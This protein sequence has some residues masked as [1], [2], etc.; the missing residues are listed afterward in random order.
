MNRHSTY[1]RYLVLFVIIVERSGDLFICQ[2]QYG[3]IHQ[4]SRLVSGYMVAF[5]VRFYLSPKTFE[6]D[7][8]LDTY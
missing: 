3:Q 2:F 5:F 6:V 1:L 7:K 8:R 4:D